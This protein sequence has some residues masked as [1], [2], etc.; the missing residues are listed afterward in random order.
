MLDQGELL[1]LKPDARPAVLM[2]ENR[3]RHNIVY[4]N[5]QTSDGLTPPKWWTYNDEELPKWYDAIERQ[6][7]AGVPLSSIKVV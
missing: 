7:K 5:S 4:D 2:E 6:L 3:F 1:K